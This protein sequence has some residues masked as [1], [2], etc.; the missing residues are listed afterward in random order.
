MHLSNIINKSIK[1]ANQIRENV[2]ARII[3]E[4]T[5]GQDAYTTWHDKSQTTFDPDAQAA[6]MQITPTADDPWGGMTQEK[7]Q[8][9]LDNPEQFQRQ[10]TVSERAIKAL[11]TPNLSKEVQGQIATWANADAGMGGGQFSLHGP[12]NTWLHTSENGVVKVMGKEGESES[13]QDRKQQ[14]LRDATKS[15]ETL[16]FKLLEL[17]EAREKALAEHVKETLHEPGHPAYDA[18]VNRYNAMRATL[19]GEAT[20]PKYNTRGELV[21]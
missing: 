10:I 3:E 13:S 21:N 19:T 6:A 18:I 2:D 16:K 4:K 17:S 15:K 14:L 1:I 9:Y 20:I 5:A 12:T 8:S 11:Q 7:I